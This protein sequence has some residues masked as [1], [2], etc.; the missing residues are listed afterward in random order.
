MPSIV[1]LPG[2]IC[3]ANAPALDCPLTVVA[4]P[5]SADTIADWG[6]RAVAIGAEKQLPNARFTRGLAMMHVAMFEAVNAIDRRYKPYKLEL[7]AEKGGFQGRRGGDS[8]PRRAR[9]A[10]SPTKGQSSIRP[11]RRRSPQSTKATRGPKAS[12][13]ARKPQRDHRPACR[14][15]QQRAGELPPVHQAR[16]LRA[17]G[18]AD[19]DHQRQDQAVGHGKGLPVPS[20]GSAG[21]QLRG[22]TRDVNEI[23]ELG[24]LQSKTRTQEQTE[25]GRFWFLT[26]PRILLSRWCSRLPKRRRWIW[27]TARGS[28]RLSSMATSDAFIAVFDAKYCHN[29]W[30]PITAIRNADLTSNPATPREASWTPLG[31]NATASR[32]SLRALH[33]GSSGCRGAAESGRETIVGELTLTSALAPGVTRK[34]N[35]LEDYSDEV[36][37]RAST[38]ASTIASPPKLEKS[39]G[40]KIGESD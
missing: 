22:W 14:R 4:G 40:K 6:A 3:H 32:V 35:R 26:G 21:T 23:R 2:R 10:S 7:A 12:S 38:P 19:R 8:R 29:F 33:R 16:G 28:L 37:W 27:S 39:M 31:V 17:H 1:Y 20:G 36:R 18:A 25:I 24:R 5:A 15:R 30:R 9:S 34:W 11:C 13:S